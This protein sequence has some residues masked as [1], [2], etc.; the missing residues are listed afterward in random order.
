MAENIELARDIARSYLEQKGYEIVDFG[1]EGPSG[2]G[3]I[4]VVAVDPEEKGLVFIDVAAWEVLRRKGSQGSFLPSELLEQR[5][6]HL[7]G[8]WLAAHPDAARTAEPARFDDMEVT[9]AADGL[10]AFLRHRIRVFGA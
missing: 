2:V 4:D 6:R 3:S 5:R 1:W 10:N 7:A 8:E 9:F